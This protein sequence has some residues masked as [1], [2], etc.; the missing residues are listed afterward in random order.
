MWKIIKS[1]FTRKPNIGVI[2]NCVGVYITDADNNEPKLGG[3]DHKGILKDLRSGK[4]P[5]VTLESIMF[6]LRITK[7]PEADNVWPMII[8]SNDGEWKMDV[9]GNWIHKK[10]S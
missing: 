7:W 6:Y 3:F 4:T 5:S 2:T 1:W 9:D 10:C 8:Q